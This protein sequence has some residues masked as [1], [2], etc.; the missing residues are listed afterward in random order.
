MNRLHLI[1][2]IVTAVLWGGANAE[3]KGNKSVSEPVVQQSNSEQA[4]AASTEAVKKKKN[5]DTPDTFIPSE[6][7]SEDLSVS[8]PVDI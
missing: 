8:Y 5:T 7:I 2:V 3:D 4:P 6:D 1:A